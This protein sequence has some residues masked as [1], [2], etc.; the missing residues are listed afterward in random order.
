MHHSLKIKILDLDHIESIVEQN[1]TDV[2]AEK[3][4]GG[5]RISRGAPLRISPH[6]P[7][8]S[9]VPLITIDGKTDPSLLPEVATSAQDSDLLKAP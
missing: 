4:V 5:A 9:K 6:S 2:E 3:I 1:I 7:L 8:P